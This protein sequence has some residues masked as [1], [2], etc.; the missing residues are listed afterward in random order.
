MNNIII[1]T[2]VL[3]FG[4]FKPELIEEV[5]EFHHRYFETFLQLDLRSL[6][7][8]LFLKEESRL[9]RPLLLFYIVAF[10]HYSQI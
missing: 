8:M 9:L 4:E 5:L 3:N 6:K 10:L 1:D 2:C 7:Y